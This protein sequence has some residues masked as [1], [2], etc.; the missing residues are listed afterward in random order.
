MAQI[1]RWLTSSNLSQFI[2]YKSC[3][4]LQLQDR[5]YQVRLKSKTQL[6]TAFKKR[7]LKMK[8]QIGEKEKNGKRYTGLTL[9]RRKWEGLG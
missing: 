8:K 1:G 3:K 2:K 9:V 6:Y 7:T 5:G 4:H